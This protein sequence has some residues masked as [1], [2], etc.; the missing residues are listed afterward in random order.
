M[1]TVISTAIAA[2]VATLQASPAVSATVERVR[3]RPLKSSVSSAIAVR[4]VRADVL[5][6]RLLGGGAYAWETQIAVECYARAAAGTSPDAAVDA[7]LAAAYARLMADQ[8]LGGAVRSLIPI[9]VAYDFDVDDQASACAVIQFVAR[10]VTA[11][12]TL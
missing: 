11:P 1:S 4:P 2:V 6:P 12:T 8:T 3:L 5:D 7:L 10:L 9:G